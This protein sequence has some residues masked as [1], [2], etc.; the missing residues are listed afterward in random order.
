MSLGAHSPAGAILAAFD[1]H[2]ENPICQ[3]PR[4][5][6]GE[7]Q[8]HPVG[9]VRRNYEAIQIFCIWITINRQYWLSEGQQLSLVI[10][11]EAE[12]SLDMSQDARSASQ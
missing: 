11:F 4:A 1:R 12:I 6:P 2:L 3:I 10:C 9:A 7:R 5:H 8:V